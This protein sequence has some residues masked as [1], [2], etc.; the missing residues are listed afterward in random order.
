MDWKRAAVALVLIAFLASTANVLYEHSYLGFFQIASTNSATQ[1]MLFD[2]T[3]AL[4]L[5]AIWMVSDARRNGK[6]FVPHLVIT[7]LFGVAG[8]LLYLVTRPLSR[9]GQRVAA[10]A[11]LLLLVGGAMALGPHVGGAHSASMNSPAH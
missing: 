1:L 9:V 6:S 7:L 2:L 10:G 5:V 11:V 3:V 4:S 8:P